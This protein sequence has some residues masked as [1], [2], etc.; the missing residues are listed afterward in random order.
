MPTPFIH[1][2]STHLLIEKTF[3]FLLLIRVLNSHVLVTSLDILIA[4]QNQ[5]IVSSVQPTW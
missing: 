2:S 4:L 5:A 3:H 1:L